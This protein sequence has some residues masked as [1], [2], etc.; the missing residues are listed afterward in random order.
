MPGAGGQLFQGRPLA[1]G[2]FVDIPTNSVEYDPVQSD[3]STNFV[4]IPPAGWVTPAQ[5]RA[6][7]ALVELSQSDVAERA[8]IGLSTVRDF[9]KGRHTPREQHLIAMRQVL[10]AEG[11][12]FL[13]DLNGVRLRPR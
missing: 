4:P 10:E 7:R 9:E 3:L 6:A 12:E 13:D 1:P 11:V 5:S 8:H 2:S